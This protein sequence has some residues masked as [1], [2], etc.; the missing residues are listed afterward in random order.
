MDSQADRMHI[1]TRLLNQSVRIFQDCPELCSSHCCFSEPLR[2]E[3]GHCC[4]S[5]WPLDN[6]HPS[7]LWCDLQQASADTV[8]TPR[9]YTT[10]FDQ[11]EE[12]FNL[13]KNPSL[14]MDEFEAMLSEFST[15]YNQTHFVRNETFKKAAEGVQVTRH[16]LSSS[17]AWCL[18]GHGLE[19]LHNLAYDACCTAEY[20]RLHLTKLVSSRC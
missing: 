10:D 19:Q 4:V 20:C 6:L 13:E 14:P 2:H 9:F 3:E 16:P 8:L 5:V 12:M 11:M 17:L 15:D 1:R 18:A 7:R